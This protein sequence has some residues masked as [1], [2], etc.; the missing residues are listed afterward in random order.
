M[1]PCGEVCADELL[2]EPLA[3]RDLKGDAETLGAVFLGHCHDGGVE[4]VVACIER[5]LDGDVVGVA[6]LATCGGLDGL[7]QLVAQHVL[8]D[9]ALLQG[10]EVL[11]G[12]LGERTDVV[13]ERLVGA[14]L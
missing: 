1:L 7:L 10:V 14:S 13:G 8:A 2:G 6:T 12:L 9:A 5:H 3:L 4:G 11:G